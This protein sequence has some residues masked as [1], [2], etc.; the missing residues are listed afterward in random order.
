[1][2]FEI[3]M[4]LLIEFVVDKCGKWNIEIVCLDLLDWNIF[5]FLRFVSSNIELGIGNLWESFDWIF[6][7]SYVKKKALL[8]VK[9]VI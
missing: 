2:R 5:L 3:F 4:R 6:I 8:I 7:G 9:K 1:M